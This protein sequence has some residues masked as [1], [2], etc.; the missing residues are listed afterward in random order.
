MN[1]QYI[2]RIPASESSQFL[3]CSVCQDQGTDFTGG[4]ALFTLLS[5]VYIYFH[6]REV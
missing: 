6:Q 3:S 1:K 5:Q 2:Y 4:E